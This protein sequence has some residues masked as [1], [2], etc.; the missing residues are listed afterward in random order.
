VDIEQ[1]CR[2]NNIRGVFA[3]PA[4]PIIDIHHASSCKNIAEL[5]KRRAIYCDQQAAAQARDAEKKERLKKELDIKN[6]NPAS[7]IL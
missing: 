1:F 3:D 6:H 5:K 2:D 7:K 4:N